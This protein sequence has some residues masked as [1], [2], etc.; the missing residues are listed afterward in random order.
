MIAV[1]GI[2]QINVRIIDCE[3]LQTH[4]NDFIVHKTALMREAE[5]LL[6]IFKIKFRN[7]RLL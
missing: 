7:V 5:A 2:L 4:H 6:K 1:F 3:S